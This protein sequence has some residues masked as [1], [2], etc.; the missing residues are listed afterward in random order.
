MN[1]HASTAEQQTAIPEG[2]EILE[3]PGSIEVWSK[4]PQRLIHGEGKGGQTV[5]SVLLRAKEAV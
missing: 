5:L 3:F 2:W 1:A 4:N